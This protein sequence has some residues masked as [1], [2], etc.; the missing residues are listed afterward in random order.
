MCFRDEM[1][2]MW[3]WREYPESSAAPSSVHPVRPHVTLVC[4][5]PGLR[6]VFLVRWRLPVSPREMSVWRGRRGGTLRLCLGSVF[7][8]CF[9]GVMF[10]HCH[11]FF[12]IKGKRQ[13]L[14]LS[15]FHSYL[16][17]D[18]RQFAGWPRTAG[19]P[20]GVLLWTAPLPWFDSPCSGTG[21]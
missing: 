6:P 8:P 19:H 11:K 10:S 20:C 3:F 1:E 21:V 15:H 16:V 12:I 4:P 7:S 18:L 14:Y 2:V 5:V 13:K 9:G 17:T